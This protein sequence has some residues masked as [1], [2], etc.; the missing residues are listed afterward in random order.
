[1]ALT[2]LIEKAICLSYQI[3]LADI[4]APISLL[5]SMYVIR[6]TSSKATGIT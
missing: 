1:M 5:K 4:G 6:H 3:K 2:R